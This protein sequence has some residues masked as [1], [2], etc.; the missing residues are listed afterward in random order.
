MA[1]YRLNGVL[2]AAGLVIAGLLFLLLNFGLVSLDQPQIRYALAGGLALAGLFF[3]SAFLAARQHWWRLIPA[4]ALFALAGMVLFSTMTQPT[5]SGALLLIGLA[6]AFVQIYLVKRTDHW[7]AILPGGFLLVLGLTVALSSRLPLAWL[8]GLLFTGIGMVFALVYL[9][10]DRR[11]QWWALVPAAILV[12]FGLFLFAG[13]N[14]DERTLLRW[15]PLLLIALGLLLAVQ[16]VRRAPAER[17]Q[18]NA[19]A[20]S[21]A[22]RKSVAA[23]PVSTAPTPTALGEYSQPAPGATVDILSDE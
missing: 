21:L 16:T 3:F 18:I 4:W 9:L 12:S 2:W 14:T 11:R 13:Q 10:G 23:Q 6:V 8:S 22:S 19:T 15:W 5:V 1:E 17:L 7:W 20:A